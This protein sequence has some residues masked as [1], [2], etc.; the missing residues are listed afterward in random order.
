MKDVSKE[1]QESMK[2]ALRNQSYLSVNI[3]VINQQAQST[4]LIDN[5]NGL[6][7]SNYDIFGTKVRRFYYATFEKNFL[8]LNGSKLI[9]PHEHIENSTLGYISDSLVGEEGQV[10]HIVFA[11]V[12][13][14]TVK[15][16]TI[17]FGQ[18]YPVAFEIITNQDHV[19][20]QDNKLEVYE[21]DYVFEKAE[22]F[23]I[24]ATKMKQENNRLRVERI[25]FGIGVIF[26][27]SNIK[28]A[29]IKT[30]VS[31]ISDD[32]PQIDFNVTVDNTKQDYN[33]ENKTST[34][35]YLET[36]QQ[37]DVQYGYQV[38]ENRVEW[39]K[40]ATLYLKT[41]SADET[42]AKFTAVDVMEGWDRTYNKGKYYDEGISLYDLAEL[43]LIDLGIESSKY[44]IDLYLKSVIVSNP[45]PKV[46]HKEALQIIANAGRCNLIINED[47]NII[48]K[49]SFIPDVTISSN[50]EHRVSSIE[51]VVL[52]NY[53]P[54]MY[55]SMDQNWITLDGTFK[56]APSDGNVTDTMF[57]SNEISNE[58][59]VFTNNPI[60]TVTL[61]ATYTSI[62][63][64]MI[65]DGSIPNG[66][67]LRTYKDN[68][69]IVTYEMPGNEIK[70]I[71][72][73][74]QKFIDF[75]TMTIEFIGTIVPNNR[76]RLSK[77]LF[78][79]FTDYTIEYIDLLKS[80]KGTLLD[81]IKTV[82]VEKTVYSQSKD[83]IK[84]LSKQSYAL[85][86]ENNVVTIEFNNP[87]YGYTVECTADYAITILDSGAYFIQMQV[88]GLDTSYQAIEVTV[89]GYEYVKTSL[90]VG[91]TIGTRGYTKTWSNPL[92]SSDI[93]ANEL[94]DWISSYYAAD[95][96]YEL[97]YR[98]DPALEAG[99]VFYIN[100]SQIDN[101]KSKVYEHSITFNG[102]ITGNIK[103]RREVDV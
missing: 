87:S 29:T 21:T 65:F 1:Y 35:N 75:D 58:E 37:L 62:G 14:V 102:A 31:P 52:E 64:R 93:L 57:V 51:N 38:S 100:T 95:K 4:A 82:N 81:K 9:P 63:L 24:K 68:Q 71:T 23:I 39:I 60:I 17:T 27:N 49:T 22:Y 54:F 43:V 3:G 59:G 89:N 45:M 70:R 56:I 55:A 67:I 72:D 96:Q 26:D 86:S 13:S 88:G 76:I 92:V 16:L 41:W 85:N 77:F 101:A 30:Y 99:D 36:G 5:Q 46:K 12:A 6:Y 33:I 84:Q 73:I 7:L 19:V 15:G 78:G 11:D 98:G 47:S 74:G 25:V 2:A 18:Y 66:L 10:L 79:K 48:L 83:K 53:N 91:K 40:L 32:V 69:L 103:A 34:M 20:I 90:I 50:D 80:P 61:E 44:D 8:Q 94:L 97:S 28:L 42:T